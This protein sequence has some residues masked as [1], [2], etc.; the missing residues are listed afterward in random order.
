MAS[1]SNVNFV[2]AS[3]F[4]CLSLYSWFLTRKIIVFHCCSSSSFHILSSL[5]SIFFVAKELGLLP[6]NYRISVVNEL[7]SLLDHLFVLCIS[8]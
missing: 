5:H 3:Y 6:F 4:D 7:S 8:Y 2:F 1:S